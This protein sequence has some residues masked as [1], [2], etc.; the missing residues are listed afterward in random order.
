MQ[1]RLVTAVL[2]PVLGMAAPA[3]AHHSPARFDLDTVTTLAG[4][5]VRYSNIY[6]VVVTERHIAIEIE[7]MNV[8]RVIYLDGREHADGGER[9]NQGHSVGR[10][11]GETLVVDTR[12]FSDNGAGN[13]FEIPSGALK[14]V[15]ERFS[16]SAD[17]K[18]IEYEY[19]LED[20]DF[21]TE[22]VRGE[23]IW[24]DRRD[25]EALPNQCDPEIARR[26]LAGS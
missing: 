8:R 6:D 17:R 1:A 3:R 5:V 16:L 10:W 15:V 13:A 24:D 26:F 4:T 20:P 23:G 25:L 2:M 14:H 11:E 7:W 18:R 9:T 19:L 21:L 22:P 12:N